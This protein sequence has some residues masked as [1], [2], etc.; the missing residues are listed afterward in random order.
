MLY[1]DM[2]EFAAG[3][4]LIYL[5]VLFAGVLVYALW[6]GNKRTFDRAAKLPLQED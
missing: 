6:P 3:F 5:I 4:G 1:E 2:R